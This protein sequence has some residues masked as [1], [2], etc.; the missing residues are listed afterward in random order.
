MADHLVGLWSTLVLPD[1]I[2]SVTLFVAAA[3]VGVRSAMWGSEP[4]HD[5]DGR[6][7][8]DDEAAPRPATHGKAPKSRTDTV[9]ADCTSMAGARIIADKNHKRL[10]YRLGATA[11]AALVCAAWAMKASLPVHPP[12]TDTSTIMVAAAQPAP[13]HVHP[14]ETPTLWDGVLYS[15]WYGVMGLIDELHDGRM[16]PHAGVEAT[17]VKA[18]LYLAIGLPIPYL[19]ARHRVFRE[20]AALTIV[21]HTLAK[22]VDMPIF[23]VVVAAGIACLACLAIS[24]HALSA[25]VHSDA[26][27]GMALLVAGQALYEVHDEVGFT[28]KIAASLQL[29]VRVMAPVHQ[30]LPWDRLAALTAVC[31]VSEWHWS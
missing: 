21:T 16:M 14:A 4:N 28:Q 11:G 9:T 23:K 30:R 25:V 18:L 2:G 15:M 26:L 29:P 24:G 6:A 3:A 12:T 10:K 19:T 5:S 27:P 7:D 13:P 8:V 22:K 17:I 20:W 31:C 1:V